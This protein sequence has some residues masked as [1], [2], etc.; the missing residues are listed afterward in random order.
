VPERGGALDC[1]ARLSITGLANGEGPRLSSL[2]KTL[3]KRVKTAAPRMSWRSFEQLRTPGLNR[4][5]IRMGNDE[6]PCPN[7]ADASGKLRPIGRRRCR[8]TTDRC[9]EVG[10]GA[11]RTDCGL[12]GPSGTVWTRASARY[13]SLSATLG[14]RPTSRLPRIQW[15]DRL[16]YRTLATP[17]PLRLTTRRMTS[18]VEG[19]IPPSPRSRRPS[20]RSRRATSSAH[21]SSAS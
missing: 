13:Q 20:A 11:G 7:C 15:E 4:L 12:T 14:G 8:P 21:R 17:L 6:R 3:T 19:L 10:R 2:R 18:L 9:P 5:P 16:Q 1:F